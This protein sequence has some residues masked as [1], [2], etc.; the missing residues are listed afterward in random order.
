[1]QSHVVL[2][3][4]GNRSGQCECF[5]GFAVLKEGLDEGDLTAVVRGSDALQESNGLS[6]L[7]SREQHHAQIVVGVAVVRILT[8]GSAKLLLGGVELGPHKIG[9]TEVG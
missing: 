9:I 3:P 2:S 4:Y 1:M 5:C 6:G 8:Q 7:A